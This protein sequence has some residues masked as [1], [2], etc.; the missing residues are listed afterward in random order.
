LSEALS[1]EFEVECSVDHAFDIWARKTN[2]WWPKGHSKSGD[3]NLVVTIEGHPSGRIY[4]RT[5]EGIEHDWGVVTAWEPPHRL[6]YWW[7]IYGAREE[8][9]FV[10]VVFVPGERS[11]TVYITH[12]GW[13][14]L[15]DKGKELRARNL[16]GW[17][18]IASTYS[19]A[20]T[21]RPRA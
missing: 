1:Y 11:T 8:A 13:E 6:A 12:S 15:G 3:P 9:T 17:Q 10:E 18:G 2:L 21:G 16:A 20:A 19:R 5:T 4:E 7:H 14:R